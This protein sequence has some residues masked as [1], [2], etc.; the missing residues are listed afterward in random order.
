[1]NS[2]SNYNDASTTFTASSP[3]TTVLRTSAL[4]SYTTIFNMSL[5]LNTE[6]DERL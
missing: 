2:I 5:N 3:N 6:R 4:G 1:M